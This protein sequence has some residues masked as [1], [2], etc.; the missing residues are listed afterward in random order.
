MDWVLGVKVVG[1]P[2]VGS[3]LV[4]TGESTPLGGL[5]L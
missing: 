2:I 1:W 4:E 3:E 5:F